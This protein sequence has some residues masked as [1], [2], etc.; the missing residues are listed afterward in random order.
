MPRK[1]SSYSSSDI[2]RIWCNN[3]TPVEQRWTFVFF[4]IIVPGILLTDEEIDIIF[5]LLEEFAPDLKTKAVIFTISKLA[6]FLRK[7]INVGWASFIFRSPLKDAII[8]CIFKR[9]N[10]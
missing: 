3:L 2:V 6:N 9:L 8:K 10:P 1:D 7:I 5:N 4:V